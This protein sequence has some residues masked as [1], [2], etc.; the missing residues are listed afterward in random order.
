MEFNPVPPEVVASA[1]PKVKVPKIL[2]LLATL[3]PIPILRLQE[4]QTHQVTFHAP[5][6]E[7]FDLVFDRFN[8]EQTNVEFV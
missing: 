1:D 5:K 7:E 8:T 3:N 4:T 6:V 2:A